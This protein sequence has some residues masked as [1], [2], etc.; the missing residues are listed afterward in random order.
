MPAWLVVVAA[1]VC[2]CAIG[3]VIEHFT[4]IEVGKI[5]GALLAIAFV[6]FTLFGAI[7]GGY[8]AITDDDPLGL[9]WNK[10]AVADGPGP[11]D[12]E[13]WRMTPGC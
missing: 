3:A 11:C 6:T 2:Y 13:Q 10:P 5:V 4:D 8:V 7:Y 9:G 12:T 1:V